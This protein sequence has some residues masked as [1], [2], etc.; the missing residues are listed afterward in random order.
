MWD[1]SSLTRNRTCILYW[2]HGGLTTG[3]L[4]KSLCVTFELRWYRD[5]AEYLSISYI[6]IYVH[7][8]INIRGFPGGSAAQEK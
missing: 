8:S 5:F 2:K 3:P 1:P 4:G 7:Y 6:R